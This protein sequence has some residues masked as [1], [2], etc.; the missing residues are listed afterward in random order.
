MNPYYT[1]PYKYD[2]V[3]AEADSIRRE[4]I[5][6]D[7]ALAL[8]ALM[9][10]LR[11]QSGPVTTKQAFDAGGWSLGQLRRLSELDLVI[12]ERVNDPKKPSRRVETWRAA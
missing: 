2:P 10:W 5:N 1:P 6:R 3:K 8:K 9:E 4:A 12:S 7:S 11:K